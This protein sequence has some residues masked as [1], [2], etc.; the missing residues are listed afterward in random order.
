MNKIKVLV[1]AFTLMLLCTSSY[2]ATFTYVESY[3]GKQEYVRQNG[4]NAYFDFD[5]VNKGGNDNTKL[6]LTQDAYGMTADE[7]WTSAFIDFTIADDDGDYEVM[8]LMVKAAGYSESFQTDR[9]DIGDSGWKW[10]CYWN[11]NE[12]DVVQYELS[13]SMMAA[14]DQF[15]KGRVTVSAPDIPDYIWNICQLNDFNLMAVTMTVNTFIPDTPNEPVPEP[16]T[17]LLM[18]TGLAGLVRFRK[19]KK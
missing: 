9:M 17:L 19:K 15:D 5:F 4:I 18:G 10:F 6:T 16:A 12:V 1:V 8:K 13:D 11:E 2:A 14:F 3:T 7:I